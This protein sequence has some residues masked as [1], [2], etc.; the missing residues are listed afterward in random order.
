MKTN[1]ENEIKEL[2]KEF[3]LS[4]KEIRESITKAKSCMYWA[5][6]YTAR[7]EEE[8]LTNIKEAEENATWGQAH[9]KV[10]RMLVNKTQE[11]KA[12]IEKLKNEL[13]Q[14]H[15]Q[16]IIEKLEIKN[17]SQV[18][19]WVRKYNSD[20][21]GELD[22]LKPKKKAISQEDED[23]LQALT[24]E[25]TKLFKNRLKKRDFYLKIIQKYS[26]SL[27]LNQ[28]LK[29]LQIHKSTYYRWLLQNKKFATNQPLEKAIYK[30]CYQ[31]AFVANHI[32]IMRL[33]YRRIW[34]KMKKAGFKVSRLTV[35]KIMNK[36][37]LL[38]RMQKTKSK[39]FQ[40]KAEQRKITFQNKLN[41]NFYAS[42][43]LQKI[44][45]DITY[46]IMPNGAKVYLSAILDLHTREIISF[47]LSQKQDINFV[48][49]TL[50]KI[51]FSN[52]CIHHS[53]QGTVYTSKEYMTAVKDKGMIASFSKK[54]TP[55]NNACIEAFWSN[56]KRETINLIRKKI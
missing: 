39:H 53:D 12:K 30:M 2:K 13:N 11:L 14:I 34:F 27:S 31:Y 3:Q 7:A 47:N 37:N 16:K 46:I 35:L 52:G 21:E 26:Q 8:D 50:S 9:L 49:Q 6:E 43:P 20:P 33:G 41:N 25:T 10:A 51:P 4:N 42:K 24:K 15:C 48:M 5:Q 36:L 17:I 56:F 19:D 1:I 28:I 54:G 45:T 22:N 38:S 29:K 23:L 55:S 32:P 40:V 18:Y 44:C